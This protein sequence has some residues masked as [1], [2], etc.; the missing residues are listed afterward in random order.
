[1]DKKYTEFNKNLMPWQ[2]T[3]LTDG[4]GSFERSS[5]KI[6]LEKVQQDKNLV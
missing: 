5:L 1:M 6:I 3:G 2:V 4:E